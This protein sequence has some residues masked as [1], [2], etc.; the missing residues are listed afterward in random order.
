M[1]GKPLDLTGEA[2][3]QAAEITSVDIAAAA[4]LWLHVMK[5]SRLRALLSSQP[6]A[7][8]AMKGRYETAD[9][10][11][12]KEAAVRAALDR[13]I[14]AQAEF[15]RQQTASLIAGA[16]SLA[17]WQ[18]QMLTAVKV[19]HLVATAVAVG[20]WPQ[21]DPLWKAWTTEQ[22]KPQ[23]DYLIRFTV[24]L[25]TGA[26][27]LT[28]TVASRA[29]MYAAA[30]RDTHRE[31]QRTLAAQRMIGEE[32]SKLGAA[33]HCKVCIQE[34]GQGWVPFGTLLAIGKR[35]CLSNCRCWFEFRATA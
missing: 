16:L 30:A 29:A 33:D 14:D 5:G 31:A 2:I 13:V 34:A 7:F 9:G 18:V 21:M 20:G 6:F 4:A 32:C 11:L 12:V 1:I 19:T 10:R 3:D 8:D 27:P 17:G 23:Y 35:T 25:G 15:M 24:E 28:G 26:Q 22:V